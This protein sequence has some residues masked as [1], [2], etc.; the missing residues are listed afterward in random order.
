MPNR[1]AISFEQYLKRRGYAFQSFDQALVKTIRKSFSQKTFCGFWRMWN[2]FSGYIF[3]LLYSLIGGN[4]KRPLAISFIF[5]TS[6][7]LFHDLL[8]ILITGSI[9][10]VFTVTFLIY[11]MIFNIEHRILFFGKGIRSYLSRMNLFPL[12]YHVLVNMIL[13]A[14]PLVAGFLVNFLVFPQ[15]VMNWL[16][17]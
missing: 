2:P 16:F 1:T 10:I 13:L 6:G 3:F 5:I 4:R 11:S 15:S 9:S 17:H 7:F 14:L 12:R 8:I